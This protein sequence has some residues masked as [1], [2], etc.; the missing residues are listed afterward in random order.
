MKVDIKLPDEMKSRMALK[1]D[2]I[3]QVIEKT[4]PAQIKSW[5]DNNVNDITNIRKVLTLLILGMK[6]KGG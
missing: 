6:S 5:I 2:A 4:E 1:S 3:F